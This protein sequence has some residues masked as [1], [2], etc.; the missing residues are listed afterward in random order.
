MAEYIER[1]AVIKELDNYGCAKGC[2]IGHHSGAVDVVAD[3]VYNFPAA[4]VA[5]VKHGTWDKSFAVGFSGTKYY[6]YNC[7][8]CGC[9]ALKKSN[10]KYCHNCGAKMDLGDDNK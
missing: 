8:V 7:S 3:V 9:L 6:M 1:E 5:E 4:D 10:E 2:V